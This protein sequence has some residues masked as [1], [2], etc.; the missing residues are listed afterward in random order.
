LLFNDV[1][2]P[3]YVVGIV[4]LSSYLR[5]FEAE[6]LVFGIFAE[7]RLQCVPA[8]ELVNFPKSIA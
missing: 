6:L 2:V 8:I 5:G 4:K 1:Q 7:S 3:L